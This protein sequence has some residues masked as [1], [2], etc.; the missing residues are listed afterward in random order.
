MYGPHVWSKWSPKE[1]SGM[2]GSI[3]WKD[4]CGY[5]VQIELERDSHGSKETT[6][7][8]TAVVL[9]GRGV[10]CNRD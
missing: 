4:C 2:D 9:G 8:A 1:R 7:E 3:F 10:A 6:L 5:Q